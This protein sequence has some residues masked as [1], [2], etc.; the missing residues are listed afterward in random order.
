MEALV[1]AYLY[2]VVIA[3]SEGITDRPRLSD[4]KWKH[5]FHEVLTICM[6][7]IL[8]Q[9][10]KLFRTASKPMDVDFN[11]KFFGDTQVMFSL[12]SR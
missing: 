12:M 3:E 7:T 2:I 10:V 9:R 6:I 5:L 11:V 4:R 1:L 8:D